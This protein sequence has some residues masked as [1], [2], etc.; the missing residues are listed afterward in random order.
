M[1]F[2]YTG[3]LRASEESG[4]WLDDSWGELC[5]LLGGSSL[6][7]LGLAISRQLLPHS[8]AR[9]R[10]LIISLEGGDKMEIE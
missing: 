2:N 3:H 6:S 7:G 9:G 5:L 10:A 4:G 8:L 1:S